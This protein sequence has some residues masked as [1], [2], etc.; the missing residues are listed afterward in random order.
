MTEASNG[1]LSVAPTVGAP[2]AGAAGG[3][4]RN[5]W[6]KPRFLQAI[7][8]GYLLWSVVP[9]VIAVVFSF[10][11]G[12]SRSTWQ[13]FSMRWWYEDPF[14]SLWHDEA[15]RTAMTQ[16]FRLSILT[17]LIAVPLGTLFAIGIDR[18]RG[19]PAGVANFGMLFSFVIPEIILG[20][21]MFLLFTNLL[22]NVLDLGT[23][24]QTIG[25]VT[26][27][28][29]YPFIIV[30]ARLLTIGPEYEEAAMDLGA[31]PNQSL[32]RVLLPLLWPAILASIA[33]VFAD[34]VDNFVTVRYL[35]GPAASEPLSV[36][37]YSAAR[38][39]P[40]PAVNAAATVML[41]STMVVIGLGWLLFRRLTKDQEAEVGGFVQ[42]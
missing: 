28:M 6:R 27:Q 26:F 16:T 23:V 29:S 18:W 5:P 8:W 14:D 33:L 25:L 37:I 3:W 35:S 30:R 20:V 11:A 39:S 10:N 13:G 36:K 19:R 24:A 42:L 31:T 9:V 12:R 21:S 34:S 22:L 1:T 40:T 2:R 4:L 32:R 15:L 7:T 17:V 38:S 41:I